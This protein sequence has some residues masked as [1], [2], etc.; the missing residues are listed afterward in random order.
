[1]ANY[2]FKGPGPVTDPVLGLVRPND[3]RQLDKEPD[4]GPWQL[5]SDAFREASAPVLADMQ[6][7]DA[8]VAPVPGVPVSVPLMTATASLATLTP[9]GM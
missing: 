5:L 4:W 1:M 6:R 2:V 8:P 3:V 9:K 7:A